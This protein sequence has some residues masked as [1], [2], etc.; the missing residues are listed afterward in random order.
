MLLCLDL[1]SRLRY[2]EATVNEV[3]RFS[4]PLPFSARR[5]LED[6][7]FHGYRLPKDTLV[8]PSIY[9]VHRDPTI[10][11]R[12]FA[13]D[14]EN[15]LERVKTPDGEELRL[16]RADCMMA[17]LMGKRECPGEPLARQEVL[18]FLVRVLQR[19]SVREP[20]PTAHTCT[21]SEQQPT[22]DYDVPVMNSFFRMPKPYP[23]V[24]EPRN[25]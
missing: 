12:P 15:F 10:W 21:Q 6:T 8:F 7:A 13:F 22:D 16:V 25:N 9:S 2:T 19:F 17:F 14:P 18:F 4:N 24:F 1:R 11:P 23:L 20:A 3:L 5:V